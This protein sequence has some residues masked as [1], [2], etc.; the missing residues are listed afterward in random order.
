M[1]VTISLLFQILSTITSL[2]PNTFW[3]TSLQ[4]LP[5]LALQFFFAIES[6]FHP[7]SH[8]HQHSGASILELQ[9]LAE[10]LFSSMLVFH[11]LLNEPDIAGQSNVFLSFVHCSP[12]VTNPPRCTNS[13]TFSSF[14]IS[15][16]PFS[17]ACYIPKA[18]VT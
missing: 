18:I 1:S 10:I 11:I 13:V 7:P 9:M 12:S 17:S 2:C 5:R 8:G 14:A 4:I 3:I 6:T 15:T 16:F